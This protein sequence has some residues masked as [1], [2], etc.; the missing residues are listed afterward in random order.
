MKQI[1]LDFPKQFETGFNAT[2]NIGSDLKG[3][4]FKSILICGMGG[5]ALTGE[6]LQ[7]FDLKIPVFVHKNYN[8]PSFVSKEDLI[9]IN[10]YSG[11]TEETL[12]AFIKAKNIYAKVI[13]ITSGGKL[14]SLAKEHL[15]PFILVPQGIKPRMAIGYQ[16]AALLK[17][18]KN[19]GILSFSEEEVLSFCEKLNQENLEKEGKNIASKIENKTPIIYSSQKYKPLA[20]IF[21]IVLNESGKIYAFYN[22]FPELNHTEIEAFNEK[23]NKFLFLILKSNDELPEINKR[24]QITKEIIENKENQIEFIEITGKNEIEKI[25]NQILIFYWTSY[26]LTQ[27]KNINPF[28]D[29]LIDSL[30][31]KMK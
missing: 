6:L 10:S 9:I 11:N 28:E 23:N 25:I 4:N 17:V 18:L 27:K 13:V 24:M 14:E 21:K 16:F 31:E 1:I 12:S 19:I 8:I 26:Y 29:K 7:I 3:F 15:I 2:G 5:S 30:K 20:Y 22:Y